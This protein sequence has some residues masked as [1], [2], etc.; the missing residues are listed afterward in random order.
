MGLLCSPTMEGAIVLAGGGS[1]RMGRDKSWLPLDGR[2]LLAHVIELLGRR[3][4]PIV[5][6]ARAGQELPVVAAPL[7]RV[8]DPVVDAGPLI[9]LRAAL[10]LLDAR[11][12]ARAY[13]SSC[14]AAG[15]SEAHVSFMLEQLGQ[16]DGAV[17]AVAC[18]P[19]GRRHPLAAALAVPAML[20]RV[21]A[22]IA[23]NDHRLQALFGGADVLAI[24]SA[25]L[26]DPE[27]LAPCNTPQEW[28]A[29]L[30]RRAARR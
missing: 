17:A 12:V 8:D 18:D 6:S 5:V 7:L 26:P 23:A 11:G 29:L 27:V 30:T 2:P 4:A 28:Q 25:Q 20:A 21:E 10:G 1:S 14:D 16:L 19:D 22:R 3:C 15:L 24:A 9:G 13:L